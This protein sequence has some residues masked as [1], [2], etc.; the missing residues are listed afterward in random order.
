ME[1]L[2]HHSYKQ[3]G[4]KIHSK[5][6]F[7]K[8]KKNFRTT[9]RKIIKKSL[10]L[11]NHIFLISIKVSNFLT[12]FYLPS[13]KN[14]FGLLKSI[15]VFAQK[16]STHL[17]HAWK[18]VCLISTCQSFEEKSWQVVE[19]VVVANSIYQDHRMVIRHHF[20]PSNTR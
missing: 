6:Y 20:R 17:K 11:Q 2:S 10:K 3:N 15:Q 9:H 14:M 19:V 13:Q 16:L 4:H 8:G 1:L 5:L 18:C 12:S 7:I